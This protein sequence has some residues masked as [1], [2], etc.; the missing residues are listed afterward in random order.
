MVLGRSRVNAELPTQAVS[1]HNQSG[2]GVPGLDLNRFCEGNARML[3]R[4]QMIAA[5]IALVATATVVALAQTSPKPLMHSSVFSWNSFKVETTKTGARRACFDARTALLDQLECH[6]T[7]LNPG[8]VPH[9]A[10]K[11]AEE[12]LLIVKEGVL[13][14][15]QNGQTNRVAAG[16]I[17]FQ[18]SNEMH[19]LRNVGTNQAVY[20]VIKI[21]PHDPARAKSE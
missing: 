7:T 15:M 11:H 3:T 10:H 19:G 9:V 8:E 18:A 12:E 21:Y 1:N 6:I 14:V 13:E 4:R 17:I 16:G 2:A 5:A 20:Y